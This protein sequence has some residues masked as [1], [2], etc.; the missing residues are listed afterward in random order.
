MLVAT[1]RRR[2]PHE[3]F[4]SRRGLE[5]Y[6][7]NGFLS[8]P[9]FLL[10]LAIVWILVEALGAPRIAAVTIGFPVANA[11]HY[12]LARAWIFRETDRELVQGYLLF[13]GNGLIGLCVVLMG[14]AL[15]TPVLDAHF[16]VARIAASLLAG[17][18]VFALNA[19]LNFHAL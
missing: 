13:L 1:P 5:L 19:R 15:F 14:F 4:L 3:G 18:L 2:Y 12:L 7:R 6:L 8:L 10:D 11:I 9:C 16:L 17:T